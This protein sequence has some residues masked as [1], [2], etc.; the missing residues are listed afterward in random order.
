MCCAF[1]AGTTF[2]LR[3][4]GRHDNV[5]PA[6]IEMTVPAR[7]HSRTENSEAI[8]QRTRQNCYV[9]RTNDSKHKHCAGEKYLSH[10]GNFKTEGTHA[11]KR[12]YALKRT[13]ITEFWICSFIIPAGPSRA[14][15]S[16]VSVKSGK[17]LP[18]FQRSLLTPS[19]PW[20]WRQQ[21]PLKLPDYTALQPRRQPSSCSPPWEPQILHLDGFH[22]EQKEQPRFLFIQ[23]V[24]TA[25]GTYIWNTYNMPMFRNLDLCGAH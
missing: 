23:F 9:E 14:W 7:R 15:L 6:S 13:S 1:Y 19:S 22:R 24:T 3:N 18:T 25:L 10:V 5:R 11:G 21:A 8:T 2:L 20:W 12:T 16:S 17:S 4:F